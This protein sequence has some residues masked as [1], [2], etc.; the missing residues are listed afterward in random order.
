MNCWFLNYYF[1]PAKIHNALLFNSKDIYNIKIIQYKI[2][3]IMNFLKN[4]GLHTNMKQ[5]NCFQHW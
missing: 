5:L 3:A 4:N 2:T 1:G